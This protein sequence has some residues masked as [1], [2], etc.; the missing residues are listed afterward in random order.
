M[1]IEG[2]A[3]THRG[4]VCDDRLVGRDREI[5]AIERLIA[6]RSAAASAVVIDGEA[7]M[8]KTRLWRLG[9]AVADAAGL[10]AMTLSLAETEADLP[11]VGLIDLLD[12]LPP[13]GE[14][15]RPALDVTHAPFDL[16]QA[17]RSMAAIL[18]GLTRDAP[19]VVAIDDVQWL[20]KPSAQVLAFA[21][22]RLVHSPLRLLIT[23]RADTE[24]ASP[25]GLDRALPADRVTLLMLRG[26]DTTGL[27][28]L[29]RVHV[30]LQLP[31]PRLIELE[32]T[33]GGNPL[34]ALGIVQAAV[35]SGR[36]AAAD[37]FVVPKRIADLFRAGLD[38]LGDAG[39][40][41]LLVAASAGV[42]SADALEAATGGAQGIREALVAGCIELDGERVRLRHPL[43]AAAVYGDA[44]PAQR[45]E[46]HRRLAITLTDVVERS[47][48]L[49]LATTDPDEAIAAELEASAKVAARR[50][51][52]GL[53]VFLA[54]HAARLTPAD[55]EFA[56]R[57]W[58]LAAALSISAG[59][60]GSARTTLE[61][62][63]A[64]LP[65]G[66]ERARVLLLLA[67]AVGDDVPLSIELCE[68][69]LLEATGEPALAAEAH[70]TLGVLTW[71]HGDLVRAADHIRVS[72]E[73]AEAA[74][75]ERRLAIAIGE[76]CHAETVLGRPWSVA[77]M[78]RAQEIERRVSDFPPWLRPSFQL[79]V[80]LTYTD[81]P[82]EARPLILAELDRVTAMG[83]EPARVGVLFRL[84]ELELRAGDWHRAAAAAD[85]AVVL[86]RQAAIEQE[87]SV[88]VM[89]DALVRAHL[90][91]LERAI[92]S[93][94]RALELAE[95]MG[96][97][98]VAVR[99]RGA[100]GLAELSAGRPAEAL[101]WLEPALVELGAMGVG[102]LSIAG[103]HEQVIEALIVTGDIDRAEAVAADLAARGTAAGR[104]WH[105]AVAARGRAL[106][107]AARGDQ[108]LA[109]ACLRDAYAAH[110]GLANPFTL[111]RTHLAAGVV[112]R[113]GRQW[114]AA[115]VAFTDALDVF[116]HLGA[117]RWSERAMTELGRLPGRAPAGGSLTESERAVAALVVAGLPNKAIAG[118][119]SVT[120]RTVEQ[121]VSRAG[122]VRVFDP[123]AAVVSSRSSGIS[124]GRAAP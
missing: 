109:A 2:I 68:R 92:R 33:C 79:G 42:I 112:A 58:L 74:G 102:E 39:H 53:G 86:A 63:S 34:F 60:P 98:I 95:S 65:A 49:A 38:Q 28:A 62:M 82:D 17:G 47:R 113:R 4:G 99:A 91:D 54:E 35:R 116:D 30:G 59:D 11:L 3:D 25:I 87:Q 117:A 67:A 90:G 57:R 1:G 101:A 69:A 48:H 76:M 106:V 10:Q 97:R 56:R 72:A 96:D 71:I 83:D 15:G 43:L 81:R 50:G 20:D 118:R 104:R 110:E 61:A 29:L 73:L 70:T 124:S 103:V 120:T 88:G 36:L 66:H 77:A 22:R 89:I 31:R 107:A 12:S 26:L 100:L 9:R 123:E 21:I 8:G 24:T 75:D 52:P 5:D 122:L 115:R 6:D 55:E 121:H 64:V 44:L 108:E 80:I 45:R 84:A 13:A 14:I 94:R 114:A 119:L 16:A 37:P 27:D 46:A 78:A 19:L 51:A 7:G 93:G 105:A 23:R 41:A 85:E 40:H 18:D 111:G 32:R